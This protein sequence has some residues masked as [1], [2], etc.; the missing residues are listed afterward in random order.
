M[1]IINNLF[2]TGSTY[3]PDLKSLPREKI[4][5]IISRSSIRTLDSDEE[6]MIENAIEQARVGG[7]ISLRKID[8]LLCSFV[9]RRKI[10]INDKEGVLKQFKIYFDEHIKI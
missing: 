3:S 1:G 10:S 2:G 5:I 4:R 6:I 9:N 7:K 8:N